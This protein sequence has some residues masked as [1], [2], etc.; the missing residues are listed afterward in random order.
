MLSWL[1][2]NFQND[3]LVMHKMLDWDSRMVL[4]ILRSRLTLSS[5]DLITSFWWSIY[6]LGILPRKNQDHELQFQALVL[7]FLCTSNLLIHWKASCLWIHGYYVLGSEVLSIIKYGVDL[8]CD[9]FIKPFWNAK[10]V[11]LEFFFSRD[12]VG[13]F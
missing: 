7:I 4:F 9:I 10:Y 1:Y 12:F 13:K 8:E 3:L 5:L 11:N 2:Y 6:I